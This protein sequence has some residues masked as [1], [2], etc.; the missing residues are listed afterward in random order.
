MYWESPQ[1]YI[2]KDVAI[3]AKAKNVFQDIR[4]IAGK[5]VQPLY[6]LADDRTAHNPSYCR[7]T[8]NWSLFPFG[9]P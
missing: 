1:D 6:P 2:E 3:R 7:L 8:P 5:V 4:P 9:Y